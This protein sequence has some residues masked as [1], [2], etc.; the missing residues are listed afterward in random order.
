M[1]PHESLANAIILRA[2]ADYRK[3]RR[4]LVRRPADFT[5]RTARNHLLQF[6]HSEYFCIL[7]NLDAIALLE[8][9]DR[10]VIHDC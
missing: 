10:E 9:L 3:A 8:R 5:A 6:F 1:N 2:V 7:S 4:A